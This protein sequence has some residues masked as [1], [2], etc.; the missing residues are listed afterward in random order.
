[1]PE[2]TRDIEPGIKPDYLFDLDELPPFY[3]ALLYGLQWAFI[4]FPAVIMAATLSVSAFGPGHLDEVRFLQLTLLTSGVFTIVQTLWGHRYP[5]LEGPSTAL[6]LSFILLAP[7][8]L[9]PIQGGTMLG[10][11]LLIIAVLSRQLRRLF[12]LFT[13]NV[14]GVI[15]ILI[16]LGLLRPLMQFMTGAGHQHPQGEGTIF[17]TSLV[18]TLFIATASYRLPGFWRSVSILIGMVA[19]SVLFFFMGRLELRTLTSSSWFT[20]SPH[21]MATNPGFSWFA[22]VSFACAYLAVT[23]NSLGS[24]QGVAAITEQQRLATSIPRGIFVNGLG[25]IFCGLL[26]VVGTVSYSMSP[27]VILVNRVA[28]RFTVTYCGIILALAA[29]S[30]KLAALLSLVPAPVVG[31]ALCVALGGQVGVGISVVASQRL[32]FRD[33]FVVGIPLLVGSMAGFLPQNL[34]DALPGSLHVFVSNSLV[35]GITLVL[36]LEHILLRK[37]GEERKT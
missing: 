10:A 8:G 26:G 20:F 19:G 18:L 4:M 2:V 5:L 23:V 1:M 31:A 33:Y 35:A 29:F 25:G 14:I 11:L 36:L 22:L 16:A 27:G 21:W 12:Q 9:P 3:Y 37:A 32:T 15:L 34:F 7:F 6:I 28:S 30:P 13:P 24:L 17:L